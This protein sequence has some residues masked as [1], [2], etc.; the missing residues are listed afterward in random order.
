M[1]K[2]HCKAEAGES[3]LF[4]VLKKSYILCIS[5]SGQGKK[6]SNRLE[7]V[8]EIQVVNMCFTWKMLASFNNQK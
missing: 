8:I 5:V 1:R 6:R 2:C 4:L 3:F 7:V